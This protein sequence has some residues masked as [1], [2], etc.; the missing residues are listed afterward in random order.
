MNCL[1]CH[2]PIFPHD[3]VVPVVEAEVLTDVYGEVSLKD[4]SAEAIHV[5]HLVAWMKP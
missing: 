4:T 3:K 2:R 1:I 5:K